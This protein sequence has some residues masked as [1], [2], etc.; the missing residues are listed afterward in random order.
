MS[1]W[2]FTI[3]IGRK[4][5]NMLTIERSAAG[6][7]VLVPG[8]I[9][10]EPDPVMVPVPLILTLASRIKIFPLPIQSPLRVK[11]P[12][13]YNFFLLSISRTPVALIVRLKQY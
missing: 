3:P 6:N 1:P 10:K 5:S 13:T 12:R 7:I 2:L 4:S 8:S 11:S 9:L